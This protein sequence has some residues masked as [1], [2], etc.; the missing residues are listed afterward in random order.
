MLLWNFVIF[1]LKNATTIP[2]SPFAWEVC[3]I[4]EAV[5]SGEAVGLQLLHAPRPVV[6]GVVVGDERHAHHHLPGGEV[7][8]LQAYGFERFDKFTYRTEGNRQ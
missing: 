8:Q 5:E 1:P 6:V 3:A 4:G 2:P 7:E